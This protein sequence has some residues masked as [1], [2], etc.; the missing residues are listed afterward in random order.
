MDTTKGKQRDLKGSRNVLPSRKVLTESHNE[1][2]HTVDIQLIGN[3]HTEETWSQQ[4]EPQCAP[5]EVGIDLDSLEDKYNIF[6][7][8]TNPWKAERVE[9]IIRQVKIGPDLSDEEHKKVQ[10]FLADW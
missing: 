2:K 1:N 9:E 3:S 10:K 4:G 8:F 6:T 5:A 7:R